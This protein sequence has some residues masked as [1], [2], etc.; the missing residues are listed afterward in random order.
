MVDGDKELFSLPD[1]SRGKW[2][3]KDQED[4]YLDLGGKAFVCV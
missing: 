3:S 2:K 4:I 1:T